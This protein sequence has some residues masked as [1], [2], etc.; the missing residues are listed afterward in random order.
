VIFREAAT[1][2]GGTKIR[3]RCQK[4]QREKVIKLHT[5][6]SSAQARCFFIWTLLLSSHF[7]SFTQ[8]H[9][10]LRKTEAVR[11]NTTA[12]NGCYLHIETVNVCGLAQLIILRRQYSSTRWVQ[13]HRWR[14]QLVVTAKWAA[15]KKTLVTHPNT[16][17]STKLKNK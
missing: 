13:Q 16:F 5:P 1:W 15:C 6:D 17:S 10:A 9:F 4:I 8:L 14:L 11:C 7:P 2:G 3:C 12:R